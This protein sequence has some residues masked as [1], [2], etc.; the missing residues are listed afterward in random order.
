MHAL[1]QRGGASNL[2]QKVPRISCGALS[3]ESQRAC[4]AELVLINTIETH[5][6]PVAVQTKYLLQLLRGCVSAPPEA[7]HGSFPL[8]SSQQGGGLVRPLTRVSSKL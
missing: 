1:A 8:P 3:Q 7:P 5:H 2:C 4:M 6:Q